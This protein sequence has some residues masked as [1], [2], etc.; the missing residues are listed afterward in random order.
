MKEKQEKEKKRS[1]DRHGEIDGFNNR[2]KKKR[3]KR[4]LLT[5]IGGLGTGTPR[6]QT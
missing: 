5:V 4:W 6:I 1:E 2:R 3:T